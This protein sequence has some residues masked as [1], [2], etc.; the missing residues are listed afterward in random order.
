MKRYHADNIAEHGLG[1]LVFHKDAHAE[2]LARDQRIAELEATL[3][4]H[5]NLS[6]DCGDGRS[7]AEK[8]EFMIH[9]EAV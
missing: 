9:L 3:L 1:A 6:W 2:I 4:R 5:Y 8:I 7:D